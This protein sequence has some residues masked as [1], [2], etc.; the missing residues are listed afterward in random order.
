MSGSYIV[1]ADVLFALNFCLD[2]FL[3]WA[4]GCFLHLSTPL[5]RLLAATLAAALYG[6]GVLVP[7]LAAAYSAPLAIAVSL[8]L[9]RAAYPWNGWRG[10]GKLCA[11]FYLICF[12][13]AGAA[14]AASTLLDAQGRHAYSPQILRAG[15]LLFALP[16]ALALARRGWSALSRVW[17]REDFL[18]ELEL[19]AAAQ[20]IRLTA[21][22]D[23]GNDLREP[24]S[25]DPVIVADYRAVR[26]LLPQRLRD[27]FERAPDDAAE[28][29][30]LMAALPD[31]DG[32]TRRLRLVPFASLGARHGLL[33]GFR[34]DALSLLGEQPAQLAPAVVCITDR[35]WGSG[36]YRA[37]ANPH[38]LD[39]QL[40]KAV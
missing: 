29:L 34:P 9:L 18:I 14:L 24:L 38:I 6:V 26:A 16:P 27:S 13:M 5:W 30:R 11:A 3:L 10:F 17:R 15:C 8:L 25:A 32:W 31:G 37:V 21:L 1:Y 39:R 23:T 2:W 35:D 19:C 33:L 40:A 36:G 7:A 12:A 4:S 28:I 20:R 22:L